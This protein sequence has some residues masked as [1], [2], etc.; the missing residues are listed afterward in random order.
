MKIKTVSLIMLVF[1]GY[2]CSSFE[3]SERE[4]IKQQHVSLE[5]IK[6]LYR[7]TK[8]YLPP[9]LA[10]PLPLYPWDKTD[11]HGL[12]RITLEDFRCRGNKQNLMYL[13]KGHAYFDCRGKLSHSLPVRQGKEFIYPHLIELLN[14]IQDSLGK[15]VYVIQG[16]CCPQH[17][18]YANRSKSFPCNKYMVGAACDFY[19]ASL[20]YEPEVGLKSLAQYY[21]PSAM[22]SSLVVY[23]NAYIKAQVHDGSYHALLHPYL[24]VQILYD[25]SLQEGVS[26][27]WKGAY[28]SCWQW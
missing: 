24:S 7:E 2:G 20:E 16:H 26:L 25:P 28:N 13:E 17:Y 12:R 9:L 11:R 21:S 15:K 23:K 22:L 14:F 3:R 8:L 18:G 1:F 6:R 19:V 10:N 27:D 5:E 4:K